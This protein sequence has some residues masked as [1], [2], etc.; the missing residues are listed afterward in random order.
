MKELQFQYITKKP[1]C[2]K[3]GF[4]NNFGVWLLR[5]GVLAVKPLFWAYFATSI[6][7]KKPKHV[8][9]AFCKIQVQPVARLNLI[10]FVAG[11]GLEPRTFGL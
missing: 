3:S 1:D 8:R 2:N 6:K 11:L 4:L 7:Q 5:N 10:V 9:S